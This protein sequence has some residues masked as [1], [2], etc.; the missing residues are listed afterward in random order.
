LSRLKTLLIMK[1]PHLVRPPFFVTLA[2]LYAAILMVAG[3]LAVRSA[4]RPTAF[5][6]TEACDSYQCSKS[7][8]DEDTYLE[9][10]KDKQICLQSKINETKEA[11]VTLSR[12]ISIIS[13]QIAV[14]VL[15]I[16]ETETEI[17]RLQRQIAELTDRIAGLN[18]SLDSLSSV[19]VKRV[20]EHY[21]RQTLNPLLALLTK[22][23]INTAIAEFK[24]LQQAQEQTAQAMQLAE[25]QRLTYD[26]QKLLLEQ[27]QTELA[28]KQA[29]LEVQQQSLAKQKS[30]QQ[31][32]LT[33]TKQN[34]VRYQEELAKTTAELEAIQ[35]IIAGRGAETEVGEVQAGDRI[36]TVIEGA[37][38]CST[39]SH[40]H[41]EVVSGG[42]HRD[43]ANYLKPLDGI[44]W[45][46][47]PDGAFGLSGDW[48]WPVEN[49]AKI[50]QGYG[51]TYY[52]RVRRAYGGAPHT[53]IDMFS[54]DYNF[55]V[56]AVKNGTLSRGSI[57]CGGG[58]LRYVK[59]DHAQ[60]GLSTYYLH[61]NY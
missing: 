7:S 60:D 32:L 1:Q 15:Q 52:A 5:A 56:K 20:T 37:S 10:I 9:C 61:V 8:Q 49:P 45:Y 40:L 13:S 33:E 55:V 29:A 48:D 43:P 59:V 2:G 34:E 21:K 58:V 39:G 25:T 27:T 24:Y 57:P 31:Y 11:Q 36:A 53:G 17:N 4:L 44:A 12:T 26:E 18:V 35:S 16:E 42:T 30:D 23:T 41:F 50:T 28:Q 51:M 6:Q 38:A 3:P 54:K 46:N 22:G 14:Q 19:L 47:N